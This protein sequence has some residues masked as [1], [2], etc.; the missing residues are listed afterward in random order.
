[1]TKDDFKNF[2][3]HKE[4]LG[5]RTR[6][7]VF[8]EIQ[9]NGQLTLTCNGTVHDIALMS[10]YSTSFSSAQLARDFKPSPVELV[11]S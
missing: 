2:E 1:M 6:G 4:L 9:N 11:K 10:A 7:F 3:A 8:V 5:E